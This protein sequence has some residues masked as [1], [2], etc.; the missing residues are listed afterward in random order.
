LCDGYEFVRLRSRYDS[1]S[2]S[3]QGLLLIPLGVFSGVVISQ[4]YLD[5]LDLNGPSK[6]NTLAIITSIYDIGCFL[7]AIVAFTIGERYGRKNTILIGS[8]IMTVG[9]V[10]Q[11]SAFTIPHMIVGRI[12]SGY[13]SL[14]SST[15]PSR[16]DTKIL[17]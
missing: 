13:V 14:V 8:A 6:T 1:T 11:T 16:H 12:V 5:T 7:G 15:P 9:A 10:L 17:S 2:S 4:D 3:C